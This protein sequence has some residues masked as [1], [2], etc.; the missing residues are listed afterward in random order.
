MAT[1]KSLGKKD[2][3]DKFYTKPE[4]AKWLINELKIKKSFTTII[5]PSAGNGSFSQFLPNCIALDIAPEAENIIQQDFLTY[6][7]LKT[8]DLFL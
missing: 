7:P 2:R 4:I 8:M 5:E 6:Y 3:N 1:T